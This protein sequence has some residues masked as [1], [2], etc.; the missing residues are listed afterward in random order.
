M[1]GREQHGIYWGF[2]PAKKKGN[3]TKSFGA[4]IFIYKC[5]EL[6]KFWMFFRYLKQ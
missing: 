2:F 6:Y 5:I 4:F 3:E 1:K